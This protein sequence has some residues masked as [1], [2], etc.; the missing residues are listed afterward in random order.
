MDRTSPRQ[1]CAVYIGSSTYSLT[2][3]NCASRAFFQNERIARISF[4]VIAVFSELLPRLE[5]GLART[6]STGEKRGNSRLLSRDAVIVRCTM[7][8]L[9]LAS[10][11]DA[12]GEIHE[13]SLHRER[14]RVDPSGT[15]TR[16][17]A[18]APGKKWL[19]DSPAEQLLR[20][21]FPKARP[22][23]L[24]RQRFGA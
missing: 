12:T 10:M 23:R 1:C 20:A 5:S 19:F 17:A 16:C 8:R 9:Q 4:D 7:R 21:I 6:A 22:V 18:S 3:T 11:S 14:Q 15:S 2:T 24:R 13:K